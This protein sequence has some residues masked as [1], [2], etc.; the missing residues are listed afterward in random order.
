MQTLTAA[1]VA[2]ASDSKQAQA[3]SA[4]ALREALEAQRVTHATALQEAYSTVQSAAQALAAASVAEARR[5]ADTAV[6]EAHEE[7]AMLRARISTLEQQLETLASAEGRA[8]EER[9][10]V[11]EV[12]KLWKGVVETMREETDALAVA[13]EEAQVRKECEG[14]SCGHAELR[15]ALIYR[16]LSIASLTR[17]SSPAR[18]RSEPQRRLRRC[19]RVSPPCRRAAMQ[20][21]P[22]MP[23]L[24]PSWSSCG[25]S[26]KCSG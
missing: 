8:A 26:S 5:A 24:A 20:S 4:A 9:E 10:R 13:L 15:G 7:A 1:L 25:R 19:A 2:A 18:R 22:S 6:H 3:R 23:R 17:L 11:A 16:L 12:K 14:P 21:A